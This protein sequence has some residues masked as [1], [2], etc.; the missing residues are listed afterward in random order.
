[1]SELS[2]VPNGALLIHNGVIAEVGP[3]RRVENLAGARRAHEID[4]TG[5]IVMPGFVDAD[6]ALVTP[7]GGGALQLMSKKKVHARAGAAAAEWARYGC[8]SVG[9][10][11]GHAAEMK[12]I[13]KVLRAHRA[14]QARPLRIRSVLSPRMPAGEGK[15]PVAMLEAL[16]SRW[17]PNV[18]TRKLASV[19]EFTVASPHTDEDQI[20][21][22]P[23]LDMHMIRTAAVVAA[24]LGYAIRLRSANPLGPEHLELALS[25]GAIAIIAPMHSLRVFMSPLSATG[26]VRVIPA[27]EGFDNAEKASVAIR[28]AIDAGAAVALAS[29]HRTCGASSYNMQ[30]LLHLAVYRLGLTP[31]EA[32]VATTWN[33]ACSLRLSHVAGSFEPGNAADLVMFE[34]PDYRELPRRAGHHD[35]CLVMRA[36]QAIFRSA[37][38]TL[39]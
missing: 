36:G 15:F 30:F 32:I 8:L 37:P 28:E 10:H 9:A 1:M 23:A 7:D 38:L 34:V 31:A 14:L 27:S 25:A 33:P 6:V 22:A 17:L 3:T 5:R 20:R 2:I 29:S 11:T 24:G 39:D 13:S 16:I 4:A 19:V 18:L 12:N 35:V 26:C 21:D